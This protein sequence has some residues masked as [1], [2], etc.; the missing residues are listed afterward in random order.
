M[1]IYSFSIFFNEQD[2][3]DIRYQTGKDWI[4]EIHVLEA[5]YTF[6]KD[7]KPYIFNG[8][9]YNS[10]VKYHQ[11]NAEKL[12]IK[13][14]TWGK[15]KLAYKRFLPSFYQRII[16]HPSWYNEKVQRFHLGKFV[17]DIADDDILIF[18]DLDEILIPDMIDEL[19]KATQKYGIITVKMHFTMFYFNL[20]SINW[21]GP[22]D[23]SHRVFLMTGKY[24][25]QHRINYDKLRKSGENNRITNEIY[26]FPEIA[27]F[28]HSWLGNEEAVAK[29]LSSY[30]HIKEHEDTSESFI[31][32][33]IKEGVSLFP[34]HELKIDDTLE[35]LPYIEANKEGKFKKYFLRKE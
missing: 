11:L 32:R 6:R 20:I 13:N 33:C 26:C 21:P 15:L 23:Y 12:F 14:N 25:K 4:D 27:G 5:N 31:H 10:Q 7:A 3:F 34:G 2:I 17:P 16:S 24:Y 8:G 30:S 22:K 19:I 29:K 1:K 28:H 18:S 9:V 35:L